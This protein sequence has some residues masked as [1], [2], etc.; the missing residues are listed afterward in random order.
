MVECRTA[1][2]LGT[3]RGLAAVLPVHTGV[4]KKPAVSGYCCCCFLG[5]LW[6]VEVSRRL[7]RSS[8]VGKSR[9]EQRGLR[10]DLP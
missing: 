6:T 9:R 1:A 4:Y 3:W 10:S 2:A 7:L 5:T 8:E